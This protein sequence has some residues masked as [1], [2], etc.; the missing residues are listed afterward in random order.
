MTEAERKKDLFENMRVS[1][2]LMTLAVPTIISQLINLVYSL[3]DAIYIGQIGDAYKIAAIALVFTVYIMTISFS[4]LFGIGG[5]SLIARLIGAG[6]KKKAKAISAF[7]FYGGIGIALLYS[8]IVWVFMDQILFGLGASDNT[9]VFARQYVTFVVIIGNL[10]VILSGVVSHLLRNVGY[11]KQ[12]SIGLSLGGI[13]NIILDPLFMFVILPDGMEVMGAAI[14]TLLANTIACIILVIMMKG[15]T[16][17]S[18]LS[19]SFADLKRID[20]EGIKGVFTVGI[21]SAALTGLFDIANIVLNALMAVHGDI[22]I[23][24]I[25]IVMR[26]ERLPNA[27]NIGLCQGM[28]PLVAYNYGAKNYSRMKETMNVTRMFGIVFSV[29]SIIFYMLLTEPIC[30]IFLNTHT[31]NSVLAAETIVF[32]VSFLRIRCFASPLQFLNYNTSYS[33]QAVGYGPGTLIHALVRELVFY[34]P[35]MFIF[36]HFFG[37]YGLVSAFLAGEGCGGIFALIL[38][39]RW[40]KKNISISA[41]IQ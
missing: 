6:E 14:A 16:K 27:V 39:A 21:P 34:I 17:D 13:L 15:V 11:S 18:A 38:F 36:D 35:F 32:A 9:I 24:A 41:A 3:A 2:A 25:G 10:P 40:K 23:A 37:V 26:A 8:L 5:G 31:G 22:Q 28:L 12:A 30:N 29:F 20:M 4:N 19:F 33:M 7:S 1:K